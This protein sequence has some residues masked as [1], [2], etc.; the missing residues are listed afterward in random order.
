VEDVLANIDSRASRASLES[1][2]TLL[3]PPL[4]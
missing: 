1:P 4:P 3:T 2:L